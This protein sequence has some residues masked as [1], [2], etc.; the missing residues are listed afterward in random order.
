MLR[1]LS[2]V[3]ALVV[4]AGCNDIGS[5]RRRRDVN[6]LMGL[7]S[8]SD[9]KVRIK[10]VDALG[11]VGD[12]RAVEP[13]IKALGDSNQFVREHAAR[14][15]GCDYHSSLGCDS[16]KTIS[17]LIDVLDDE[18]VFVRVEAAR[19]LGENPRPAARE[20]LEALARRDERW[21]V[22]HAAVEALGR[23]S[24]EESIPVLEALLDDEEEI[25][26]VATRRA[27]RRLS[28]MRRV[29]ANG[30]RREGDIEE[31]DDVDLPSD[32]HIDEDTH[33]E[34][35]EAEPDGG[36][37]AEE[38]PQDSGASDGGAASGADADS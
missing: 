3:V 6:G 19:S 27:L 11:Y 31:V 36:V 22:R 21:E 7:L 38:A 20:P 23:I 30:R 33:Q 18:D 4:L 16:S 2:A 25:V 26:R 24:Q 29:N 5:M 34:E 14:N 17:P 35:E 13:L 37:E 10:A 28:A 12:S 15:L 1:A 32:E 8:H 9:T